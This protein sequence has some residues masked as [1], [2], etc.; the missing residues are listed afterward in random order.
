LKLVAQ[1]VAADVVG[2]EMKTYGASKEANLAWENDDDETE[3]I[4]G[5]LSSEDM[6]VCEAFSVLRQEFHTKFKNMWA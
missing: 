5:D 6:K 4:E 2:D 3:P 1:G